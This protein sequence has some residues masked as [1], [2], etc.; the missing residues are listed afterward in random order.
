MKNGRIYNTVYFDNAATTWPKPVQVREAVNRAL[1]IYGA[2]PGRSGYQMSLSTSG[3]IYR[4]RELAA[5]FFNLKDP[6][7]VVFVQNCTMALNI[8]I[9]G[10]LKYGGR[11]VVSD[12]EHNAVMRP[13]YAISQKYPIYD[14]ATVYPGDTKRTLESFEKC[15]RPD[16]R[17]IICLHSSNVF[18]ICLPVREIGKLARKYGL[19]FVVDAAQSAGVAPIDMQ[20]DCID[21]LCVLF[22]SDFWAIRISVLRAPA[23]PLA[24]AV[25]MLAKEAPAL[26]E[27]WNW[28]SSRA[29]KP[30]SVMTKKTISELCTPNCK[31]KD[32]VLRV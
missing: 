21:Y 20:E 30:R 15:I 23:F 7:K 22:R 14:V 27:N 11:V 2:N 32:A 19:V 16:T 13:L 29:C 8:V 31:P 25:L 1:T 4:C 10:L 26:E 6:S 9:K 12:L 3:K 28:L 5:E 24:T 18:G 17:A